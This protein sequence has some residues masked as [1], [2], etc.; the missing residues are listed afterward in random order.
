MLL[1]HT[2]LTVTSLCISNSTE[3]R[4]VQSAKLRLQDEQ[5]SRHEL[6]NLETRDPDTAF[7]CRSLYGECIFSA[8]T[9]ADLQL[10]DELLQATASPL[11]QANTRSLTAGFNRTVLAYETAYF[12]AMS[13]GALQQRQVC[14]PLQSHTICMLVACVNAKGPINA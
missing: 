1:T 10:A 6:S 4:P 13:N 14:G 3:N 8:H 11:F 2:H 12:A 5:A 7:L 9:T